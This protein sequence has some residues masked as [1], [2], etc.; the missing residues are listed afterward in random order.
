MKLSSFFLFN[1][2]STTN[3]YAFYFVQCI[4]STDTISCF[5]QSYIAEY[6]EIE[7]ADKYEISG[8]IES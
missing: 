5:G 6:L 7:M 3:E 8:I 2:Q 4:I 1:G